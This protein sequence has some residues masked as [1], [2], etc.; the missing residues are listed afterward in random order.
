MEL[1]ELADKLRETYDTAPKGEKVVRLHLF[2]IIYADALARF[3][4][5]AVV[6]RSG[7]PDSY[8]REIHKGRNLARYVTLKQQETA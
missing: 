8:G 4:P 5:D 1:Q 6:K 7:L 3:S 2:G